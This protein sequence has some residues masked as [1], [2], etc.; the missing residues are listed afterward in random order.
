[1]IGAASIRIG[2]QSALPTLKVLVRSAKA[3]IEEVH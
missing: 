3:A 1:M 2:P